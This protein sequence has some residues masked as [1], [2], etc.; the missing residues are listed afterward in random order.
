M[1]DLKQDILAKLTG[2]TLLSLATT[3]VDGRPWVRYVM[4]AAGPDLTIR[5]ATHLQSRKVAHIRAN[6][7]V[8]VIGGV[9]DFRAA[10]SYFQVEARA[11]VLTDDETKEA[12]WYDELEQYF[13]G[14]DDPGFCILEIKPYRIELQGMTMDSTR[15]WEA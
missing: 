6:P 8:H 15:I 5:V 7:E 14:P 13:S 2:P 9:T 11:E 12:M 4:G 3:T 1:S 10:E